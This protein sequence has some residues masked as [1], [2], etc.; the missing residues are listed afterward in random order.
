MK[1]LILKRQ[2]NVSNKSI[3]YTEGLELSIVNE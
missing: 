2:F 1:N 3:C